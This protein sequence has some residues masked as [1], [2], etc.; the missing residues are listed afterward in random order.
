V[1]VIY[2]VYA[3]NT[4][5]ILTFLCLN[6]GQERERLVGEQGETLHLTGEK[7]RNFPGVYL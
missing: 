7:N 5:L 4:E 1:S 6:C 2:I 3:A